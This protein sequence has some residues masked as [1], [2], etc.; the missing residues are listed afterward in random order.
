[1]EPSAINC[2]HVV[3][4][5]CWGDSK[6]VVVTNLLEVLALELSDELVE[7][8]GVGIDTDGGEDTL[9]V[10]GRGRLVASQGQEEVS[11]EVLHFDRLSQ[12]LA[13]SLKESNI[14]I[15]EQCAGTEV[16]ACR[17]RNTYLLFFV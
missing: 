2:N 14:E 7:A 17:Q 3:S 12:K 4:M 15:C 11:G 10:G 5:V 9:D 6:V 16:D 13:V 8:L 1:M